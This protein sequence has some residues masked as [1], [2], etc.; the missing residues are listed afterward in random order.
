MQPRVRPNPTFV[1]PLRIAG[2]NKSFNKR[3]GHEKSLDVRRVVTLVSAEYTYL[4][5]SVVDC[6]C[7]EVLSS[8]GK[9]ITPQ[10]F[11]TIFIYRVAHPFRFA[12]LLLLFAISLF[13]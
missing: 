12:P 3:W 2:S 7:V 1:L 9:E 5:S 13:I 6:L 10:S 8:D 4:I 11:I